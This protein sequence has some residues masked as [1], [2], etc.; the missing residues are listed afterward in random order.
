MITAAVPGFFAGAAMQSEEHQHG[1]VHAPAASEELLAGAQL[2][3]RAFLESPSLSAHR[4]TVIIPANTREPPCMLVSRGVAYGSFV[5]P[6]GQ[7]SISE[8]LLPMDIVGIDH[9][10]LGRANREVVAASPLTYRLLK[11]AKIRELMRDHRVALRAMAL[12]GEA[13]L[14]AERHMTALTR[15]DA[16]GR[17]ADMLLGIYE[18]LRRQELVIRPTFNLPLTQDQIADHL[19][20][21]MVHVSRTLRR[22]R[23]ERIVIVDRHVVIIL[24]LERLRLAAAGLPSATETAASQPDRKPQKQPSAAPA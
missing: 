10:V 2:L 21:T 19:G 8:I 5:L 23:E 22:L 15:L 14:R 24:D 20:I 13:R 9:A 4:D 12:A 1:P 11:G 6:D 3:R 17:V 7:R 16:R 18:R